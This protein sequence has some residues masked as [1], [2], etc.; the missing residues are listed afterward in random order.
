LRSLE[1]HP[2]KVPKAVGCPEGSPRVKL[3]GERS[4][5]SGLLPKKTSTTGLTG[6]DA[7]DIAV[8]PE[9]LAAG[10]TKLILVGA[11]PTKFEP[12]VGLSTTKLSDSFFDPDDTDTVISSDEFAT[13]VDPNDSVVGFQY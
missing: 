5:A 11:P 6:N 7:P 4:V 2:D 13:Q 3:I 8:M 10:V 1:L 12:A 9:P